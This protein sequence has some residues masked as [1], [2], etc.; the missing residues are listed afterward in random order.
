MAVTITQF[1][2]DLF[3]MADQA[4]NG[5]RV[6]FVYRGVVFHLMPEK[7]KS[8]LENVVG[9][10]VLAEGVDPEQACKELSAEMEAAWREDWAEI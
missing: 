10:P 3:H 9:Q 6:A 7:K 4:L 5:E 8:K 1:R 2:K